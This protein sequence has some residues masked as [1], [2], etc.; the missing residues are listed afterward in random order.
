MCIVLCG[1]V[2]VRGVCC[3]VDMV[4]CVTVAMHCGVCVGV[5]WTW[6]VLV[7]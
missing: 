1:V 7:G 2:L 6:C 5:C 3:V 4:L